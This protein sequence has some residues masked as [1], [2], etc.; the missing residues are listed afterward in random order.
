M[1]NRSVNLERDD[2]R[3]RVTHRKQRH[4][5]KRTAAVMEMKMIKRQTEEIKRG[6]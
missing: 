1:R 4:E 5:R 2:L 6:G 3:E